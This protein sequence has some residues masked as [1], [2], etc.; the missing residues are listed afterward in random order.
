MEQ[1]GASSAY[2]APSSAADPIVIES[3]LT[4]A[5]WSA[6]TATWADQARARVGRVRLVAALVVPVVAGML[7]VT[8]G[9]PNLRSLSPFAIGLGAWFF[10]VSITQRLYQRVSRPDAGG[11]PH[12]Q[13][14]GGVRTWLCRGSG[15]KTARRRYAVATGSWNRSSGLRHRRRV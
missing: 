7:M 3:E 11:F 4:S 13:E 2:P 10:A 5:D 12:G 9:R 14:N 1:P 8:V 15:R 6:W